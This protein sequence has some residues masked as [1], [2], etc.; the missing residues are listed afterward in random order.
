MAKNDFIHFNMRLLF[1]ILAKMF[2]PFE[3]QTSPVSS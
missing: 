3:Q 2:N 1:F